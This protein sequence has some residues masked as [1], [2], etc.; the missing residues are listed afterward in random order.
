LSI[1]IGADAPTVTCWENTDNKPRATPRTDTVMFAWSKIALKLIAMNG[2]ITDPGTGATHKR[3]AAW[4]YMGTGTRELSGYDCLFLPAESKD[5]HQVEPVRECIKVS[6]KQSNQMNLRF[7]SPTLDWVIAEI[8]ET[9]HTWL[10]PLL[11]TQLDCELMCKFCSFDTTNEPLP[12][13]GRDAP[14]DI[15]WEHVVKEHG[16]H[17]MQRSRANKKKKQDALAKC[18]TVHS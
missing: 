12:C 14:L 3:P 5:G 11:R 17:N 8:Q 1:C 6:K 13:S 4:M 7:S 2:A 9:R 15:Q 16:G 18:L 10:C